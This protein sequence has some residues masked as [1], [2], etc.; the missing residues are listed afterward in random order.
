MDDGSGCEAARFPGAQGGG[1]AAAGG[2][3]G[4]VCEVTTLNDSGQNSFREC[5]T[6]NGAR[7]VAFR[8]AGIIWLKNGI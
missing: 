4:A 2:R 3:G 1:A 6:R 7:T 8:T 5:L